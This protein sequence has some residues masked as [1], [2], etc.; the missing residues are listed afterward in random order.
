MIMSIV[1]CVMMLLCVSSSSFFAFHSFY[2]FSLSS[3]LDLWGT[4][5][6]FV[7]FVV[8]EC[9]NAKSDCSDYTVSRERRREEEKR[10]RMNRKT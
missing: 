5:I 4:D 9:G 2:T 7:Q 1:V 6:G 10:S 3:L 8:C